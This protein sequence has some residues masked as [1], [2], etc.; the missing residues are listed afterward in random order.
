M[1]DKKPS[2]EFKDFIQ[3]HLNSDPI[4]LRLNLKQKN[5]SFNLNDAITQIECRQKTFTKLK[6]FISSSDFLF[7]DLIS[8]EQASHQAVAKFHA[9][10]LNKEDTVLD[11]TAGLG[12]DALTIAMN[13]KEV[14]ALDIDENKSKILVHNARILNIDNLNVEC[15]DS[16]LFLQE[17]NHK[18]DVIFI[19]PSRRGQDNQRLYN[20]RHCSPDVLSHQDLLLSKSDR[21]LIKASPLLDLTQTIKDLSNI[22]SISAIGVKGECKELLIELSNKSDNS[23]KITLNAINLDNDGNII[24][25][26]N[27]YKNLEF[28]SSENIEKLENNNSHTLPIFSITLQE[29]ENNLSDSEIISSYY[30]LEPSAMIMKLA[31]WDAISIK[32]N[33]QKLGKSSNIFITDALPKEFPGRVSRIIK[34]IKKQDRKSLNG[35]PASVVSRN[36]PLSSQE[37]RKSLKLKEGD[38][39]FIYA[40]RFEDTPVIFLSES[41][42]G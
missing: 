35:F 2:Q 23:K 39:Y 10:F 12:I 17:G 41:I 26:F 16:I 32:Y 28:L 36:H 37:I 22:I 29:L 8:A 14:I 9:S 20:L 6:E 40:S 38:K 3:E 33:A 13:T 34:I 5:Y 7:P 19:D 31:P 15:R 4:N 42:S 11:M 24:S 21:I 30:I 25:F 18:F 27:D 1:E